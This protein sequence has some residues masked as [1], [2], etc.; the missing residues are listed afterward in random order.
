MVAIGPTPANSWQSN[1]TSIDLT[2]PRAVPRPVRVAATPKDVVI[3][4]S[5]A[6]MIVIDMQN[7]FC[8]QALWPDGS[9][10]PTRSPIAPLQRLLPVLRGASVPVVWVNWGNRADRMNLP[11]NVIRPF[12]PD[13]NRDA[14]LAAGSWEAEIDRALTPAADDIHVAK[15]RISGFVDTPLDSILRNLRVTTLLFAGVNLD[16]CVYATLLDAAGLGYDC[17]LV[18]DCAATAS[19]DYC[20]QATLYN[21]RRGFGF[22]VRADDVIAGCN[23]AAADR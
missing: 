4:L 14:F 5:A 8:H 16:Q 17:V 3:D 13:G 6:A 10:R 7:R 15:Y 21:V 22:V 19:P 11:P 18:E 12:A 9:E 23:A 2:R 20:T 1:D